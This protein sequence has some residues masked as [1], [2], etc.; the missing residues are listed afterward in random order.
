MVWSTGFQLKLIIL[1]SATS[2]PDQIQAVISAIT[3][4]SSRS[5]IRLN[6]NRSFGQLEMASLI[7]AYE[8]LLLSNLSSANTLESALRN[9]TWLLPGRFEDAELASEG[10]LSL[11]LEYPHSS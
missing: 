2:L 3:P 1:Y 5:S 9:I 6:Y 10:C 8:S 4:P 11:S 7:H